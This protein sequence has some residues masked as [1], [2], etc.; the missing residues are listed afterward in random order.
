M[1]FFACSAYKT[2]IYKPDRIKEHSIYEKFKTI[3]PLTQTLIE[4]LKSVSFKTD[5]L[6]Y[7]DISILIALLPL[8]VGQ[9]SKS[10][11]F[12]KLHFF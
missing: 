10:D 1:D 9:V 7:R 5:G 2:P 8:L 3:S 4:E 11:V 6:E 12:D